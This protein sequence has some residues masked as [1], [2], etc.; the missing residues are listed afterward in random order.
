M[1]ALK[2]NKAGVGRPMSSASAQQAQGSSK[3][4]LL[5]APASELASGLP[6]EGRRLS[7]FPGTF[8]L[9]GTPASA[10]ILPLLRYA[11]TTECLTFSPTF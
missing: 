1:A 11:E 2:V 7:H 3:A 5:E 9:G 6:S 8:L 10:A 4:S